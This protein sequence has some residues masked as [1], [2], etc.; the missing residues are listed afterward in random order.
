M[1]SIIVKIDYFGR[2]PDWFPLFLESCRTNPSLSWHIHTDCPLPEVYPPNVKFTTMSYDSYCEMVSDVLG[3][4]F[5]PY[6]PYNIVS[7][8]PIFGTIHRD[9]VSG[10]DF[11]AC[12]DIDLIYGDIRKIYTDNVLT[13]N[14]ISSHAGILS[15]H[16]ALFKNEAWICEAYRRIP[17]WREILE[18]PYYVEWKDLIDEAHMTAMFSSNAKTRE[19]FFKLCGTAAPNAEYYENNFFQEQWST[20]FTVKGGAKV[21]HRGGVKVGPQARR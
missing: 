8:K 9:I 6:H 10:F 14:V 21:C 3:V 18:N 16:F 15:G 17:R 4:R 2:F 12:S 1:K 7:L 13:H 11:F 19:D 5:K 20:P